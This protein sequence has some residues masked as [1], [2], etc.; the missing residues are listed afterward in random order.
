MKLSKDASKRNDWELIFGNVINA[1]YDRGLAVYKKGID[2]F[3]NIDELISHSIKNN[4][5][6]T[7][8]DI[9]ENLWE[10]N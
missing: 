4:D 9:T 8:N 6:S 2:K 1:V 5:T 7:L 3:E 10:I